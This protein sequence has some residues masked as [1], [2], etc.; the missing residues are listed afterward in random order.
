MAWLEIAFFFIQIE[1]SPL[2]A[3]QHDAREP[4]DSL[5]IIAA[6]VALAG[7]GGP[8]DDDIIVLVNMRVCGCV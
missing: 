1:L 2:P 4:G 8:V 3:G 7:R 5:L 6:P